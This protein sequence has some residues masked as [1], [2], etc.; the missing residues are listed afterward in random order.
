MTKSLR[1]LEDVIFLNRCADLQQI[2]ESDDSLRIGA[3]VTMDRVLDA[4]RDLHPSYAEMIRRYGSAQV[5][6][7]ATIGGNIAN[8][9]PIGDN[10]PAQPSRP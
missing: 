10:P 1:D 7:A 3:G 9:S 5:R 4:V 6:A 2:E 8:G